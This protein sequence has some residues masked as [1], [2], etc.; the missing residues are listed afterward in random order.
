M[1]GKP[2]TDDEE[3]C[4]CLLWEEYFGC[5]LRA[6]SFARDDGGD[7]PRCISRPR[8]MQSTISADARATGTSGA[9][10]RVRKTSTRRHR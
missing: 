4:Y 5:P 1:T 2:L 8:S 3:E 6:A 9:E 7:P 10:P